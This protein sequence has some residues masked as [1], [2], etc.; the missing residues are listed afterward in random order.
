VPARCLLAHCVIL[1]A[2]LIAPASAA[3]RPS[4][5]EG[6]S[7]RAAAI[8]ALRQ[9]S[10]GP[11]LASAAA[12]AFAADPRARSEPARSE[13]ALELAAR[14]SA[15]APDDPAIGWIQVRLCANT[16]GCDIRDTATA[17][18]WLDPDNAAAW[19]PTLNA[20]EKDK[21]GVEIDRVIADM[22]QGVRF[23]FYWNRIVVMLF[24]ALKAVSKSLPK[25]AID[26]DAGR[27]ASVRV[28][29]AGEILPALS[30]L[31][32]ACR[33]S[34]AGSERREF[35]QKIAKN[36][37][38]GDTILAQ[39]AGLS[40]ERHFLPADGR[41]YRALGERRRVL[42]W[43]VASAEKFD[44]PV[45]PWLKNAHARWRVARMRALRRDEDVLL[46]I[47]REIG[48]PIDPPEMHP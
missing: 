33:E 17:M 15:L 16:P 28:I 8:A 34:A 42:E 29:A 46:A 13:A 26:S 23:D 47:L 3:P 19:L 14:A 35:C 2:L 48:A 36:L 10:D 5:G 30:P 6:E 18:R 20:A 21:D 41:E 38:Q 24:D 39:L 37:Q 40:I 22:A 12:L 1:G 32:E 44:A 45:L 31:I 43:R 4:T 9:R 27:L 11:S 7:W 25:G